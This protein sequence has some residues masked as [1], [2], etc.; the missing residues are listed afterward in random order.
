MYS[1]AHDRQRSDDLM[2]AGNRS[3]GRAAAYCERLFSRSVG[4][5]RIEGRTGGT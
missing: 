5:G 2:A 3:T 4:R 1:G